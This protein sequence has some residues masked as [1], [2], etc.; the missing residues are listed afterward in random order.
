MGVRCLPTTGRRA[1]LLRVAMVARV[2]CKCKT[3]FALPFSLSLPF[4]A[5]MQSVKYNHLHFL[6]LFDT[7]CIKDL[8]PS[9]MWCVASPSHE[10]ATCGTVSGSINNI[11]LASLHMHAERRERCPSHLCT[12]NAK[13]RTPVPLQLLQPR[14]CHGSAVRDQ[15][16]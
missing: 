14:G 10:P 7:Y 11:A 8:L 9:P 6:L 15:L 13:Q 1:P 12:L 3:L 2:R 16:P 4:N 5:S